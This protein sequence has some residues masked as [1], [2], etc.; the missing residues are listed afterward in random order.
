M[1]LSTRSRYG[2][3]M[4][5][6]LADN[7]GTNPV[8]LKDIAK[9]EDI[10]EKYL[11]LIV[12]PLRQAGL[13]QST[14]GAHGGYSLTRVP[15]RISAQEIFDALEEV[16][17]LV[18]CIAKPGECSRSSICPTRD[19]WSLLGEKIRETLSAVTLA[20]LVKV[21]REKAQNNLMS[22]I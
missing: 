8:F 9:R 4:M 22:D 14:R 7:F 5:T 19:V 13:I 1:K 11:S 3:R 2:L 15:D 12:I 17:C 20:E 21:R 18:D 16:T 10:S 6:D